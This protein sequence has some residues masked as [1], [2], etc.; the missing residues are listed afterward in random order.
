MQTSELG[1][2]PSDNYKRLE[3]IRKLEDWANIAVG[4]IPRLAELAGVFIYRD[5]AAGVWVYY[6][7]EKQVRAHSH[8]PILLY[9]LSE[10]AAQS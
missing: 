8:T 5:A 7:E 2:T 9:L 10:L 1:A 3:E 4:V 6:D